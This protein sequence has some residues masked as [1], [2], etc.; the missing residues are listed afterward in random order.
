MEIKSRNYVLFRTARA[1]D[2]K[3]GQRVVVNGF[4]FICL[5]GRYKIKVEEAYEH[6]ALPQGISGMVR[7]V[8]SGLKDPYGPKKRIPIGNL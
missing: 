3:D 2:T 6:N 5:P 8:R 7:A 1:S 4:R